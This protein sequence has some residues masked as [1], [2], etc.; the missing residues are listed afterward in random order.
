MALVNLSLKVSPECRA[1]LMR[2]ASRKEARLQAEL[3]DPSKKYGHQSFA[4]SIL[5]HA[6]RLEILE[7]GELT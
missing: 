6:A 3:G 7:H 5:E 1:A 2:A 4:R